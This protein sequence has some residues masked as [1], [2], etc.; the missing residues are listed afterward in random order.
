MIDIR[1]TVLKVPRLPLT[2]IA[3]DILGS[4]YSLSIVLCGDTL[5]QRINRT[6]RKK[7]YRPNVLSFPL[8]RNEGELFLNVHCAKREARAQKKPAR[9]H[10][11]YLFIHGCL[12]LKGV[13]HGKY[14]ETLEKKYLRAYERT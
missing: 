9:E 5:A 10:L 14:M 8:A 6:Y 11:L 7:T 3:T 12:H 2:E 1:T 13:A 4:T